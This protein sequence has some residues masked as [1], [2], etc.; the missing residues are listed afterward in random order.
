MCVMRM[1]RELVRWSADWKDRT[2]LKAWM[3][4]NVAEGYWSIG[5]DR[6][7]ETIGR[8]A[9]GMPGERDHR[10]HHCLLAM[11]AVIHGDLA[12]AR[13][14]LESLCD[15]DL[16]PDYAFIISVIEAVLNVEAAA[17]RGRAKAF[18][19]AGKAIVAARTTY[20]TYM[21]EPSRRRLYRRCL[22]RI[23]R[24]RGGIGAWLWYLAQ[25][26]KS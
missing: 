5:D 9:L 16:N 25:R 18:R 13:K 4:A 6:L 23:A 12:S 17:P 14:H 24:L 22:R 21:Q 15:R 20:K 26:A 1:Y 2:D 19:E 8:R 7:A 10:P 11:G 3:L